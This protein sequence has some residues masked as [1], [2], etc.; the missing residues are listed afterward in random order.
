MIDVQV[1]N[2]QS[3]LRIGRRR[4]K[5]AVRAAV[6]GAGVASGR[7]SVAVVD[8][9]TIHELNRRYLD[10]DCP[11]DVIS[12]PLEPPG[13]GVEGEI[14]VSADTAIAAAPRYGW[15]AEE[16]FLRY[17]VHGALHLAG[18][19]DTTPKERAAM[20]RRERACLARLGAEPPSA[21][22]RKPRGNGGMA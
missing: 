18:L 11:T 7:I 3:R 8:D 1:A 6:E 10:H 13:D 2:L 16:E 4:V 21:R 9:P 15:S 17:V 14:V 20:R 22:R 19:D 12:F 5:A